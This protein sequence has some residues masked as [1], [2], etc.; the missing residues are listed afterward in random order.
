MPFDV[1]G[2]RQAGYSDSEIQ[3]FILQ[4]DG[5]TQAR[6]HGYTDQEILQN[7]GLG[8]T[9][10]PTTQG[11]NAP[12][13]APAPAGSDGTT[14]S[15]APQMTG[16]LRIPAMVGSSLLKGA[17]ATGGIAGDLEDLAHRYITDPVLRF[18]G[19]SP[20][21]ISRVN[22]L[23]LPDTQQI[24][25]QTGRLGLT[26]RADL[27]PGWGPHP[28]IER[29]A[30]SSA[31][32]VGSALPFLPFG[33]AEAALP[34]IVS[35]GM[36]GAGY[37]YGQEHFPGEPGVPVALGTV[38]GLGAGSLASLGQ[39]GT[40][41]LLGRL[42]PNAQDLRLAGVPF[43]SAAL[44]SG[45]SVTSDLLGP[46]APVGQTAQDLGHS[47]ERQASRLGSSRS[48]EEAGTAAQ[49]AARTWLT[50]TTN[51]SALQPQLARLW[52]PVDAA[53]P[54]NTPTPL[55]NFESALQGITAD[56]GSLH[57]LVEQLRP[58]LPDRLKTSLDKS[59]VALGAIPSWS[60]VRTLRTA[61]GDAKAVPSVLSQIGAQNIDRLY[62]AVTADLG[63]VAQANG[64][65]DLFTT[66][67]ARSTELYNFAENTVSKL[68]SGPK[69]GA[70]PKPEDAAAKILAGGRRGGT[71]LAALRA[72]IPSAADELASAQLRLHGLEDPESLGS[73]VSSKFPQ[74][75]ATLSPGAKRALFPDP[76]QRAQIDAAARVALRAREMGGGKT[77]TAGHAL[78]SLVGGT[79][80]GALG[81]LGSHFGGL[82]F[83]DLEAGAAGELIGNLTPYA[84]TT[85][86]NIAANNRLLA[87]LAAASRPGYAFPFQTSV[88]SG[89]GASTNSLAPPPVR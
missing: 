24:L 47:I 88:S 59:I 38:A 54:G 66:A 87:Y 67:N 72:N 22:L 42:N 27:I 53:I 17:L 68:I 15:S 14:V 49:D 46:S 34:T 23:H 20:D 31:Q 84:L 26:D 52:A 45:N 33:D 86:R 43:R 28:E 18:M 74:R 6:Q 50:D 10:V 44:T 36:G 55:T 65:G 35:S 48:L 40:N 1:D 76:G 4:S 7:F 56:G 79:M 51:P 29:Y 41:L 9:Q 25:E 30:A 19:A 83:S 32:G 60:D 82:P 5:A 71:D 75:W 78:E 8:A 63:E 81:V 61:L 80:G 62:A 39:R 21:V 77:M 89:L 16:A 2:A 12:A 57:R 58:A 37:Q 64:A 85:G 3:Q 73:V 70:D 13:N 69:P 11:A